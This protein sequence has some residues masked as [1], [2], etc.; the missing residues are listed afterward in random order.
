M[1]TLRR[2]RGSLG[3][4]PAAA[5]L[6][7][8]F[9]LVPLHEADEGAVFGLFV[10]AGP[11]DHFGKNGREVDAFRGEPVNQLAAIGGV[12]SRGDDAI[13]FEPPEAVGQNIRCDTFVG[14]QEFLE[15]AAAKQHHVANNE[16]RPAI[17]EHLD[18][19]IQGAA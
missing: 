10:A 8:E 3:L 7:E 15:G 14:G 11:E 1:P 17:A 16:Q 18:G 12:G 9:A 2:R 4:G 6:G 5:D 19:G 13:S